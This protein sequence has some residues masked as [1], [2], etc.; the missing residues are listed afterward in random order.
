[1]STVIMKRAEFI[2]V[3]LII[4]LLFNA[5]ASSDDN[6]LDN[7]LGFKFGMSSKDAKKLINNSGN[8]ILKNEKDSKGIRTILFDGIIVD[9]PGIDEAEKKSRFHVG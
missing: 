2:F 3:L 6:I 4:F 8:T 9:Y 7:P 1:M 5:T